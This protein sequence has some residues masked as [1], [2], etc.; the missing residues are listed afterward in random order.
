MNLS[1]DMLQ[2]FLD[3]GWYHTNFFP[4][5]HYWGSTTY[6]LHT[7][8]I[9][10]LPVLLN[11]GLVVMETSHPSGTDPRDI[12]YAYTPKGRKLHDELSTL[13]EL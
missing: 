9:A 5:G 8:I 3:I 13:F 10:L 4:E 11:E 1:N 2:D 12:W 6:L 7:D